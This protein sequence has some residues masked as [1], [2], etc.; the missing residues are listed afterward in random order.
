ME[1][2]IKIVSSGISLG[3]AEDQRDYDKYK[4]LPEFWIA[5]D[6][7][8]EENEFNSKAGLLRRLYHLYDTAEDD[9]LQLNI[10]KFIYEMSVSRKPAGNAVDITINRIEK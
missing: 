10:I 5:L 9:K 8:T 6:E 2:I 1:R 4:E 7:A 3:P